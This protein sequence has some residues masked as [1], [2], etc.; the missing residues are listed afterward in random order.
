M[1][2]KVLRVALLVAAVSSSLEALAAAPAANTSAATSITTSSASLNGAGT[3]NGE[4]TTGWFRISSTNPGSCNDTFGVRVPATGGTNLGTGA[5]SVN[6]SQVASGLS[7]GTTYYFCAIVQ[8]A[9]GTAFGSVLTFLV[10]SQPDVTTA[11]VTS[12][13]SSGATL[14]GSANPGSAATTGWFRYS[15]TNPGS[16]SDGFGVRAPSSG[17]TNVGSG[18]TPVSY[19]QAI[20]GLTPGTTYYFCAIA[21]NTHGTSFGAVLTFTVLAT[22]PTVSTTGAASVTGSGAQLNG[23]VIPG[24]DA[25]TGWFRYSTTNPGSCND[26]FGTRSP[27]SGG[28]SLGSGNSSVAYSQ[29]VSGLT[30]ATT[31]YYCA[32]ASNTQG[33]AFG[34]VGTFTTPSAPT[35]VTTNAASSI[36]NSTATLWGSA[37]PSGAAATGYFRYGLTNPGT[38][39]D[40]FGSRAPTSSGSLLGSGNSAQSFS[41][42]ILGLSAGTTYYFCAIA[43]NSEGTAFGAVL[44]FITATSP[45]VTTT[46]ATGVTATTATMNGSADPNGDYTYGYFR[47]ATT[48]PGSCNDSFGN[49]VPYYSSSDANLGTG[50]TAVTFSQPLTGLTP[51][52]TYYF[53]AIGRNAYGTVFGAVLNF[54]TDATL[55][56]VSTNSASNLTGTGA[57]LSGSANPGGAATTAWFRYATASPGTCNDTFGTRAPA[58]GGSSLGSGNTSASFNQA[59]SGLT[60][61]TT[62]YYCAIAQN[63]KG[64]AFGSVVS[65]VTP[66][67]PLASTGAATYVTSNGARLNGTGTPNGSSSTGHFRYSTTSPGSCNDTFGSRAPASGPDSGLGTSYSAQSFI[68]DI[69]GLTSGVTYYFCAIVQSAEGIAFG[70]VMSFTTTGGPTVSTNAATSVTASSATMNGSA[71]PNGATTNVYFRYG[72]AA[73]TVCNDSYGARLPYYSSSDPS[74]G[75]GASPMPFTQALTGLTPGTTYYF[76]AAAWNNVGTSFGSVVSFTTDAAL[77]TVTTNNASNLTGTGAQLGASVNPGGAATTVW[78]RYATASPGGCN[79]T[80]GTRAPATGGTSAGSGN[81]TASVP[82]AISGLTAGATYYYCAIASNSKGTTFGSVVSFTTPTPP[83]ATTVAASSVYNTGATLNGTGIPNG[84]ATL[85]YFRYAATDPGTCND[86]FGSRAP[87]SSGSDLGAGTT[88]RSFS[89]SISSLTSGVT[90]YYCAITQS[91]EGTGFGAVMAFTTAAIPTV[92]TSAATSVTATSA[93]MNGSADPNGNQ[94]YGYFRYDTTDPGTCSDSFGNRVPYYTSSDA[95]L[96]TGSNPVNFSQ[97]LTGLLPSTTYYFC[98]VGRNDY[99]AIFGAVLSFTTPATPPTVSTGSAA[100]LTGTSAEAQGQR[101][102]RRRGDDRLVPLRHG[103]PRHLQ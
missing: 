70:S 42:N 91:A 31:Y 15:T 92:T 54:T 24:G 99:G 79:D 69:S 83:S 98:A 37:N 44:S 75:S 65:F 66:T 8:N 84:A 4:A 86:T 27:A 12:V 29:A 28:T 59:I 102:P 96:G 2:L 93:T 23:S 26:T 35:S 40:T 13:T 100:N 38:C 48:D 67:P 81:T 60:A 55:P 46:A 18:S 16:C 1:S 94:G 33:T 19:S 47:Y 14:N 58:S 78:F 45:T 95:N 72:T 7:A 68:Q 56:T 41:Q 49:R 17:G 73:V 22:L 76:C 36:G 51:S 6:Y 61:G 9:S 25:A 101:E 64:T 39:N 32:I 30:G 85:G 80:F 77:P 97:A 62:Y 57:T 50:T 88:A 11:A 103:E 20:T 10:P 63:L 5:A 82:Q 71:T 3:P 90:Y 87:T 53:C 21:Q 52:T 43:Q 34:S 74:V 89:Q